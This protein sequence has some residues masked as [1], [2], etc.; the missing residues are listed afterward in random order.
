MERRPSITT[1]DQRISLEF[2]I[3]DERSSDSGAPLV[4]RSPG[5]LPDVPPPLTLPRLPGGLLPQPGGA[6]G[7]RV[8]EG[9]ISQICWS[10]SIRAFMIASIFALIIGARSPSGIPPQASLFTLLP[11]L[12]SVCLCLSLSSR[13]PSLAF[14]FPSALHVAICASLNKDS[15]N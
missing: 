5:A 8:A 10:I 13:L 9:L 12:M 1:Q 2:P 3:V 4:V 6:W 11:L 7:T 15:H 14:V